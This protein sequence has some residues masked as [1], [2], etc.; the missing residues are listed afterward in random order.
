MKE[1][2]R[3]FDVAAML[4]KGKR[5]MKRVLSLVLTAV[6]VFSTYNVALGAEYSYFE[7]LPHQELPHQEFPHQEF[8]HP[9]MGEIYY[10]NQFLP[11]VPAENAGS[12][13]VSVISVGIGATGG[14]THAIGA[15][16]HIFAGT[17]PASYTFS[18]WTSHS[19]WAGGNVQVTFA[20]ANSPNTSFTMSGVGG[21]V[22]LVAH[23]V[24]TGISG[25]YIL[26]NVVSVGI[27]ATGSGQYS[28]GEIVH[29]FA[30]TPPVGYR[31]SHWT[32]PF[33]HWG[34]EGVQVTFADAN[35]ASTSFP[36]A[37]ITARQVTVIAHFV[38][39]GYGHGHGY[40]VT[41]ISA[42]EGASGSG[43]YQVGQTVHI[44]AG[45]D[46]QRMRFLHW[47][48][49][50]PVGAVNNVRSTSFTMIAS[51]VVATAVFE[52]SSPVFMSVDGRLILL[53]YFFPGDWVSINAGHRV[54]WR[55][56]H[57]NSNWHL[58]FG[59]SRSSN[60]GFTM[61]SGVGEQG[62]I[63][64]AIFER[65]GGTNGWPRLSPHRSV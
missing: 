40:R 29:I 31:F 25:D 7:E 2:T 38:S 52:R 21:P 10:N 58:N 22:S 23:F 8:P 63:V 53:G 47:T 45:A 44:N 37:P 19:H 55:F 33:F 24:P 3:L 26:V 5:G 64:D 32:A 4:Y 41:V 34:G 51:D 65:V 60:T 9:H 46:T 15:T 14:G 6:L 16:V 62:I 18:H 50:Q 11:V 12:I 13:P 27:G 42:G 20:D 1:R 30:G 57:W 61:I 54:G 36:T 35:S 39:I 43:I 28:R 56:S 17:P 48:F 59:N 49:D